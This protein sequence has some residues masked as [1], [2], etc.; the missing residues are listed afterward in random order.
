MKTQSN[1]LQNA[2]FRIE[3]KKWLSYSS[4]IALR[5]LAALEE[6]EEMTQKTLAEKV[7]VSPQYINKVLKGQENLSLQTIAKLSE[8]LNMELITFPKFLFDQPINK[9]FKTIASKNQLK[10]ME[11]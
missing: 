7:G 6:S 9:V 4:N 2:K 3:N 1:Y 11:K 5:V 8:A 10:K